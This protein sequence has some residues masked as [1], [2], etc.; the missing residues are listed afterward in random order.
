MTGSGRD[1]AREVYRF[2]RALCHP[3]EAPRWPAGFS[4]VPF[5]PAHHAPSVHRLLEAGYANGSGRVADLD[6]WWRGLA[7]DAEYDPGLIF[8]VAGPGATPVA[9]AICWTSAFVKDIV[10]A[11]S[12]RRRGLASNLLRHIFHV[13]QARGAD[14]VDLKVHGD[15]RHAIAVYRSLGMTCVETL[16]ILG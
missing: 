4:L 14:A 11:A 16:D 13:F 12:V 2:R 15:N 10:V 9:V 3:V 5:Q 1:A 7:G 6:S 8:L